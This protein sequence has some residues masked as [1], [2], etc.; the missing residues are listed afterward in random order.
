[1]ILIHLFALHYVDQ[2]AMKVPVN[3]LLQKQYWTITHVLI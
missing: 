2:T 1:M 3:E